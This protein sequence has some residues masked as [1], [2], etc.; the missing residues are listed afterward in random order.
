MKTTLFSILF[1]F[2]LSFGFAQTGDKEVKIKTS[3]ICEMCKE[4]LERNLG[5]SKG[6]KY[7]NLDLTDKVMTIKYNPKKTN[8][9]SIK[10]T[11]VN[12]GYD[13]D[14]AVADQKAHDKLPDC[15]QKTA[16]P[17]SDM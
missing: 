7:A 13:A 16:A 2:T 9:A 12:T 10:E 11:I 17:H 8:V 6:V 5:L 1:A 14:E 4:R 15:C 3:A